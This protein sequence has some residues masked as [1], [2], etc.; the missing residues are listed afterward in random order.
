MY[1]RPNIDEVKKI[2]D[3]LNTYISFGYSNEEDVK[4]HIEEDTIR[5]LKENN[6]IIGIIT[7]DRKGEIPNK[8]VLE[9]LRNKLPKQFLYIQSRIVIPEQR[10]KGIGKKLLRFLIEEY[11][12]E[13]MILVRWLHNE[14]WKSEQHLLENNFV[15][16]SK[17]QNFFIDYSCP[18]CG[19]NCHCGAI[20][21]MRKT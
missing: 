9:K 7:F 13:N 15:V 12:N 5:I 1:T 6:E 3:L 14:G 17:E 16:L 19:E 11:S 2:N 4:K 10:N 18:Y 20:I 8:K 21:Y